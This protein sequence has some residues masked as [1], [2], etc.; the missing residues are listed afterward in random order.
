[1]KKFFFRLLS[2]TLFCIALLFITG[3][4]TYVM[5]GSWLG[6]I[7]TGG[8]VAGCIWGG[9][10]LWRKAS[11]LSYKKQEQVT[12]SEAPQSDVSPTH[13]EHI[14]D[15]DDDFQRTTAPQTIHFLYKKASG[16]AT[17]RTVSVFEHKAGD[18]I[19]GRCH[20]RNATRTFKL[21]RILGDVIDTDTGEIM[22][23]DQ[24][25][26][27]LT[28]SHQPVT[29]TETFVEEARAQS[30]PVTPQPSIPMEILF[31]GIPK[32]KRDRLET[33]AWEAG[34]TVRTDVT[35]NLD[36]MVQ[37]RKNAPAKE[38]KALAQGVHIMGIEEFEA[39]LATAPELKTA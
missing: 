17:K 15:F 25:H 37:G 11:V 30:A 23:V 31:T 24:Y 21:E 22:T 2:I 27:R 8:V 33:M 14:P 1:M 32:A 36:I 7:L 20:D 9:R 35:K 18:Y 16:E 39:L 38:A 4:I 19:K 3:V 34:H 6:V 10:A 26:Q 5:R 28:G 12:E 13:I 29:T